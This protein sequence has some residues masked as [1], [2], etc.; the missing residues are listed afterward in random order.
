ML[1]ASSF[2]H[3]P[4]TVTLLT[5]AILA[6]ESVTSR[7]AHGMAPQWLRTHLE[8]TGIVILPAPLAAAVIGGLD[9]VGRLRL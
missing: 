9:V 6:K 8:S 2:A 1:P 5:P 3:Q 4:A 7:K